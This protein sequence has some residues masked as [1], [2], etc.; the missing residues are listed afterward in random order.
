MEGV[1]GPHLRAAVGVQAGCQRGPAAAIEGCLTGVKR[2]FEDRAGG[3]LYKKP[4]P[5]E[6]IESQT[7]PEEHKQ[8]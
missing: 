4:L 1:G 3:A 8:S 6:Y 5:K 7:A 2:S